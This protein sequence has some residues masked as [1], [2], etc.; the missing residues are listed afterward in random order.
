MKHMTISVLAQSCGVGVETVRFYQRLGLLDT[1]ER[2]LGR[3]SEGKT[4]RY[5]GEHLRTL[6]FI[7]AAKTAGFTLD[8]IAKLIALDETN[9]RAQAHQMATIR[10]QALDA[11]ILELRNARRALK[12]LAD[13]CI[14]GAEERCPI[15][16]SFEPMNR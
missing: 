7:R 9:D 1:P 11:K 3:T 16:A 14:S 12:K 6:K 5:G 2:P 13:S 4:R 10:I 15:L 8:E